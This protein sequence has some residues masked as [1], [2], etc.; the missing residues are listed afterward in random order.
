MPVSDSES[1]PVSESEEPD[2]ESLSL[3]SEAEDC[4][5]SMSTF[6][7]EGPRATPPRE[8]NG[9]LLVMI[10]R[11]GSD[12]SE[13]VLRA[14]ASLGVNVPLPFRLDFM[15]AEAVFRGSGAAALPG[16]TAGAETRRRRR[17]AAPP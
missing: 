16:A 5:K 8:S 17:V 11:D 6:L 15:G 10:H 2:S 7:V 9:V 12:R 13:E 4:T 14:V 3:W 1:L